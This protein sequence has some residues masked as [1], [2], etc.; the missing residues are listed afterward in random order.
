MAC[1]SVIITGLVLCLAG[2]GQVVSQEQGPG[3]PVPGGRSTSP[4][5][6][7]LSEEEIADGWIALFDGETLFGWRAVG[8]VQWKVA[9]GAIVADPSAEGFLFTTSQFGDFQLRLEFL[10][11]R[12]T[13]SGVF[14]RAPLEIKDVAVDCYEVNIASAAVS[15]YP[16]GSLVRRQKGQAITDRS[17]WREMEIEASGPRITVRVDSQPVLSYEDPQP[18][19]RG[20]IALQARQGRIAF[21]KI[22]LRPVGMR[23]LFNSKDLTGWKTHPQS[24]SRA[25]V[26]PEGYLRIQGGRGQLETTDLFADFTLQLD[27]YVNGKG[28]NSGVF[29]RCVPGEMMNGYESQIHNGYRDGDRTRPVDAGTGAIFRR[30]N[31]RKVVSNDFEWFTKTI[32]VDGPHMA[33]WVNGYQVT[34]WT[35]NR[36]PHVNPRQGLRLEAG[37]IILQGHDPGTDILFRNI[38]IAELPAR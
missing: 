27:V 31:A 15:E 13:N 35:D 19:R 30:Q 8:P 10:A 22:K 7:I 4:L 21:R 6:G 11:E 25:T 32:H 2:C 36:P 38:R 20:H 17:G 37:S 14:L 33:V 26:T 3:G 16:T 1:G 5:P 34:D 9:D 18:V 23:A 24:A 29:F 28:L 12:E